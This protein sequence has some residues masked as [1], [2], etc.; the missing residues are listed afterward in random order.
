MR[1]DLSANDVVSWLEDV[2]AARYRPPAGVLV[3]FAVVPFPDGFSQLVTMRCEFADSPLEPRGSLSYP[4]LHLVECWLSLEDAKTFFLSFSGG[5]S[6]LAGVSL[7]EEVSWASVDRLRGTTTTGWTESVLTLRLKT[8]HENQLALPYEPVVAP[9]VRPYQSGVHAVNEWVWRYSTDSWGGEPRNKRE[10]VVALPDTRARIAHAEWKLGKVETRLDIN[11]PFVELEL[12][13]VIRS[14]E[15]ATV[16]DR[17]TVAPEPTV[18]W[19][20]PSSA[21]RIDIYLLHSDGTLLGQTSLNRQWEEY[22]AHAGE[23]TPLAYAQEDLQAGEGQYVE[24]KSY[25]TPMDSKETEVVRTLVAFSNQEGGGR[26]YIGVKDDGTPEDA[27]ALKR[28]FNASLEKSVESAKAWIAKL[29]RERI[30][31]DP[32]FTVFDLEVYGYVV[33]AVHVQQGPERPYATH[34][35][36]VFIRK[37]ATNRKPDPHT[38]LPGLSGEYVSEPQ[39]AL[40]RF[41]R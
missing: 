21:K 41:F 2:L 11:V 13:A 25:I 31:R 8:E 6:E 34:D 15:S 26:L 29:A 16:E 18:T 4:G 40:R 35:N 17:R 38:E 3:S 27:T 23:K 10:V 5:H 30:K 20:V 36:D 33:L 9:S 37:G 32:L 19:D 14:D 39:F 7:R 1:S 24:F 22:A 12:Q 28:A